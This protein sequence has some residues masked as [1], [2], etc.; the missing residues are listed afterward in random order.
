MTVAE[1]HFNDYFDSY[2][3]QE[4]EDEPPARCKFCDQGNLHWSNYVSGW[5]LETFSGKP[6]V[7]TPDASGFESIE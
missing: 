4:D 5:R 3:P 7:C 6:H 1:Q 2:D